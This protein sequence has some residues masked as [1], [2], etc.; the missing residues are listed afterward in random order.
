[1]LFRSDPTLL[2]VSPLSELYD[3]PVDPGAMPILAALRKATKQ[4]GPMEEPRYRY[5][6]NRRIEDLDTDDKIRA[7]LNGF[8]DLV[9]DADI[10]NARRYIE[11]HNDVVRSMMLYEKGDRQRVKSALHN[12]VRNYL[13]GLLDGW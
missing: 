5:T 1:V 7:F 3:E 6:L 13:P 2:Q 9:S 12:I 4:G 8:R 11:A 10:R